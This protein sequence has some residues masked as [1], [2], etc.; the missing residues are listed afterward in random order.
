[1]PT[2]LTVIGFAIIAIPIVD[3]FQT[4][5]HPAG[6]GTLSDWTAHIIWKIFRKIAKLR[7]GV[8]TFAGPTAILTIIVKWAGLTILGFSFIYWAHIQNDFSFSQQMDRASH[9]TFW[10][11]FDYSLSALIT[12]TE[13]FYPKSIWLHF[14]SGIEAIIGFGLLTASVSWLLSIYPVLEAQ[15]SVAHRAT[16]LHEAEK[17]TGLDL[18]E[19]K[20]GQ[21]SSWLLA[22][23]GD[24]AGL[25]NQMSQFPIVYYF[26]VGE[27]P[28]AIAG[29]LPYLAELAD[30]A[31]NTSNAPAFRLAGTT[32]GG[33]VKDFANLLAELF[34]HMPEN[35]E[36]E[37]L[38]AYAREH[39]F[40]PIVSSLS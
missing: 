3:I 18:L 2:L 7:R 19:D 33:A 6:R 21:V 17:Q 25:R 40:K 12:Q 32:L 1:V 35:N 10:G 13:G 5:F 23:A 31:V 8:L 29:I 16:L 4:L 22:L 11:A 15:R 34:L 14:I 27:K 36:A 20:T 30:R 38:L 9:V 24:L 26:N 37:I 39:M 28:T